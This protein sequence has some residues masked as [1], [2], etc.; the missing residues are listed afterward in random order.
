MNRLLIAAVAV[1]VVWNTF[2][3]YELFTREENYG[4]EQTYIENTINSYTTDITK[5]VENCETKIV[6]VEASGQV[7][8]DSHGSGIVWNTNQNDIVVLTNYHLVNDSDNINVT[9]ANNITKQ[10]KLIGYDVA[11]DVALLSVATDFKV[12]SIIKGDASEITKGEYAIALGSPIS[13]ALQGSVTFGIISNNII[14]LPK[15]S[16]ED[17]LYDYNEVLIQTDAGMNAGNSGGA[18]VNLNGDLLG[19]N[20]KGIKENNVSGINFAISI[21]EVKLIVDELL[22]DGVVTRGYL[23]VIGKDVEDLKPYEKSYLNINLEI[24]YGYLVTSI[25]KDSATENSGLMVNDIITSI[26]GA[27]VRNF[28]ELQRFLY[29]HN[30]GD[31]VD[32]KLLRNGV[33]ESVMVELG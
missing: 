6:S 3:S 9:F 8:A 10:A 20:S 32:V 31:Y 4:I 28:E 16:D 7:Y 17:G 2:L 33:E 5:T 26:D 29:K 1:L 24:K 15:D 13:T 25:V 19:L 11:S 23:G 30:K 12:S 22:N 18:L 27:L 14:L 21:N